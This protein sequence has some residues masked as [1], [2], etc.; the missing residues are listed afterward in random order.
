MLSSE[1]NFGAIWG[2]SAKISK[3]VRSNLIVELM[4]GTSLYP[5]LR[6]YTKLQHYWRV[7]GEIASGKWRRGDSVNELEETIAARIA[8]RH[9]IMVPMARV[10]IYLTVKHLIKPGQNV[11]LSPY[12]IADVVN[13]VICAGGKPVFA[14]IERETCNIDPAEIER[15]I[16]DETGLVLVTHLYGLACNIRKIKTI[17]DRKGVPLVED[18]AQAFSVKVGGKDVG[19][20]GRAGVYSFGLYKNVVSFYGGLVITDDDDLAA[21][22]R[23]EMEP[24]PQ[25]K[26]LLFL[27]KVF[28]AAVTD[29]VTWP[30]FFRAV[31]FKIFRYGTLH[32]VAAINDRLKIDVSP[33]RISDFPR[34]YK[35]L[36]CALQARLVLSQ[37][38]EVDAHTKRRIGLAHRYHDALKGLN[39]LYLPPVVTE[40]EHM[41]WYY[42]VQFD[43]REDLVK[44][45]MAHGR[46]ITMSYHRNC[47]D[48]EC[49]KD[50]ARDCPNARKTAN[51]LIYLPSYPSYP[52]SEVDENVAVLCRY[53][54]RGC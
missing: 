5:R 41:Y 21:R 18:A 20:F 27:K 2:I 43:D 10:G 46:D 4:T 42:P 9:A 45:A 44:Y 47:A 23:K 25:I 34:S 3:P 32:D 38:D 19:S 13:M 36:P 12:T 53:F 39:Q 29:A 50:N 16:D 51:S 54:Q 33:S 40:G 31:T 17:C 6:L 8:T 26:M 48:L 28:E 35:W 22:I 7:A 49:F 1:P 11:I 30:T 15:L 24:W 14:D 52:E 37:I